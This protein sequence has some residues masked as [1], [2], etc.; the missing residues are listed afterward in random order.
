MP[1]IVPILP[2]RPLLKSRLTDRFR[3]FVFITNYPRLR[4]GSSTGSPPSIRTA[5]SCLA[6]SETLAESG[7][8]SP[9]GLRVRL[10]LRLRKLIRAT[11]RPVARCGPPAPG[12]V[13]MLQVALIGD[14]SRLEAPS[15]APRRHLRLVP[16]LYGERSVLFHSCRRSSLQRRNRRG[17][18]RALASRST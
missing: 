9:T 6:S 10:G 15:D 5:A 4:N 17:R 11:G 7:W 12:L 13:T 3:R 1:E 2:K 18:A 14:R 8:A 16:S